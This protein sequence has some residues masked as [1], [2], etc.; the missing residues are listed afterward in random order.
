MPVKP[1]IKALHLTIAYQF[2]SSQF[3]ELKSIVE[4]SVDPNATASWEIRLY[5]RDSRFSGKHVISFFH[6]LHFFHTLPSLFL[7]CYPK[8]SV[9]SD[10]SCLVMFMTETIIILID[11]LNSRIITMRFVVTGML[12][13]PPSLWLD[14]RTVWTKVEEHCCVS[15]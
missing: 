7:Q 2:P 11:Q 12:F 8:Q 3:H 14:C 15:F 9:P 6:V 5:S 4:S 10:N 13:H 1:H